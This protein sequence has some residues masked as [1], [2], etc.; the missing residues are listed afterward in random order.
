MSFWL[1]L[2]NSFPLV[3]ASLALPSIVFAQE[4]RLPATFHRQEHSLSCE[5][6][7]LKM[8]LEVQGMTVTERELIAKLPFDPTPKR[9]GIWGDP[10]QA[11]V[12]NIDGQMLV[13]G[14][15]VHWDP[16]AALGSHYAAT[17]VLKH[18][19]AAELARHLKAGNPVIIWGYYGARAVH[20]WQTPTGKAIKAVNGEHTRLVYGF[21]G[22]VSAPTRF[23][24][25]DPL[26]GP[27]SW[28]SEELMFNWSALNHMGVV[29]AKKP[30]WV[31][32]PNEIKVWEINTTNKVRRWITNWQT[33]VRRG[34]SSQEVVAIDQA[35]LLQY[36]PGVPIHD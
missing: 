13:T 18:G 15:G 24:L 22:P 26:T 1:H 34:G 9:N 10:N 36:T 11:F 25:L 5:I 29:V 30:L 7:T 8:A 17:T 16:I 31:R 20:S 2:L 21:D 23:Y 6:A 14:Y 3:V 35:T 28:S 12:G 32:L 4:V 27:M 33:F 19:S